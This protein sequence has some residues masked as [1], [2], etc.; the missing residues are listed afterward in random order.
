MGLIFG[1]LLCLAGI[2]VGFAALGDASWFL[3]LVAVSLIL[4][5]AWI[6]WRNLRGDDDFG[7]S[8]AGEAAEL[9][10]DVIGELTD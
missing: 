1:F 8:G 4:S 9:A 10:I 2:I 3:G 5:G 6:I 7:T